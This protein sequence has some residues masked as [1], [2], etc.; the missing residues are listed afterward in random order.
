MPPGQVS[1]PPSHRETEARAEAGG[2]R[3][4]ESSRHGSLWGPPPRPRPGGAVQPWDA[5]GSG[6]TQAARAGADVASGEQ[7]LGQGL[8]PRRGWGAGR[9]SPP[10]SC[11]RLSPPPAVKARTGM[12]VQEGLGCDPEAPHPDHGPAATLSRPCHTILQTVSL[13]PIRHPPDAPAVPQAH[14][15]PSRC[16]PQ[17]QPFTHTPPPQAPAH[18]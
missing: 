18:L 5:S 10:L 12:G 13:G 2:L 9:E 8:T 3:E 11:L 17:T 14:T 1:N 7:R 15:P 16:C 4:S 6:R